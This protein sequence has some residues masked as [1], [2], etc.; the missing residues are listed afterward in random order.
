[1]KSICLNMIVKNERRVIRRC[2]EAL[3]KHIDY[4]VIVDTGSTDGTQAVIKECLYE[5]PG[6]LH[7]RPWKNFEHNRN[8]ALRLAENKMDYILF[9]DADEILHF[10]PDFDKDRL[11]LDYYMIKSLAKDVEFYIVKLIKDDSLWNWTQVL[12]EY[13]Q[14]TGDVSGDTLTDV[15]TESV[16][17]GAR[18]QDPEKMQRDIDIL[19]TAI[20]KDPH[21]ARYVF[22]LAQTYRADKNKAKA[23]ETYQIRAKMDGE[24]DETFWA[25]FSIGQLQE[26]MKFPP[27]DYLKSYDKAHQFDPL[28]AEPLERMANYYFQHDFSSTAYSLM[29]YAQTLPTPKPL[30]C[31]Y[32]SWV[33]DFAVHSICADCAMDLG[34]FTEARA[35]YLN[36]FGKEKSPPGLISH[37]QKQLKKIEN[38]LGENS[39]SQV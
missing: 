38:I 25:L 15:W 20:K 34:K 39:I 19:Q 35:M 9:V 1:M 7:E 31:G 18:S 33:Y 27:L 13:I 11:S 37:I 29:K 3:K 21:N 30:T 28:R 32:Y 2:L 4:W 8:E 26:E 17:D 22:Y 24:K 16:Q 23:L 12:H 6:E 10:S 14:H 5:Y 36:I